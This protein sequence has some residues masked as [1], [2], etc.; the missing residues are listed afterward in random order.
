M[1]V[2]GYGGVFELIQFV[3]IDHKLHV[4]VQGLLFKP[5][6]IERQ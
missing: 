2:S 1:T 6:K 3:Q 4:L 5:G